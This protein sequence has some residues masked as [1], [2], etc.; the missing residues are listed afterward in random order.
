[1]IDNSTYIVGIYC[2]AVIGRLYTF[3]GVGLLS[4]LSLRH[5]KASQLDKTK[6]GFPHLSC[7]HLLNP[8]S[9][10]TEEHNNLRIN[11]LFLT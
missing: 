6:I 9:P 7:T 11:Y 2:P 4:Y 3:H 5:A 10:G 1:M 8:F